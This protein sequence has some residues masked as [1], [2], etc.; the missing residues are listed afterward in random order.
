MLDVLANDTDVDGDVLVITAVSSVN[1]TT[2][3]STISYSPAT[4]SAGET[5]NYDIADGNGGSATATVTVT[6]SAAPGNQSPVAN[7]DYDTVTR[8]TGN[9]TNSVTIDVVANDTDADGSVV[10]TT[11]AI[12]TNPR[13][14]V[15]VVN[16]ANGAIT[17]T[18]TAGKRGSDAFGYTVMDDLGATSNEATVRVDIL[19]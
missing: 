8:N 5:F 12:T 10:A 3:G 11:V 18:P 19:K 6:V 14:G 17:Y 4:G 15:A 13:K 1:A 9:S 2:D 16:N 7:D